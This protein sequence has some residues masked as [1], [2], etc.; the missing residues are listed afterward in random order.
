MDVFGAPCADFLT[1]ES[2]VAAQLEK[3][4]CPSEVSDKEATMGI[5]PE[6]ARSLFPSRIL[7]PL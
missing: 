1:G 5:L 7:P 3:R 6:T 2:L 4:G